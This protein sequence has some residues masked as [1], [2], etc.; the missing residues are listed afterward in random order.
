MLLDAGPGGGSFPWWVFVMMPLMMLGMGLMMWLMMRMMMGMGGH[1]ASHGG[2][3]APPKAASDGAG[4]EELARLH[5]EVEGLRS[6]LAALE[7]ESTPRGD[8]D[9]ASTSPA[10]EQQGEGKAKHGSHGR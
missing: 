9:E 7:T 10:G 5:G 6:R 3:E 1:G 4:E 2:T 8:G